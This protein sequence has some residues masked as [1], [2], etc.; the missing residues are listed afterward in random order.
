MPNLLNTRISSFLGARC[1][2]RLGGHGTAG[3][4]YIYHAV[5]PGASVRYYPHY[6]VRISSVSPRNDATGVF[7]NRNPSHFLMYFTFQL[8][9]QYV[10][11][12]CDGYQ[13]AVKSNPP[14]SRHVGAGAGQYDGTG[15]MAYGMELAMGEF[16]LVPTASIKSRGYAIP[17][18]SWSLRSNAMQPYRQHGYG[19]AIQQHL[20]I[21]GQTSIGPSPTFAH[22]VD[23]ALVKNNIPSDSWS[24][25]MTLAAFPEAEE[26]EAEEA[27]TQMTRQGADKIVMQRQFSFGALGGGARQMVFV[28]I[29]TQTSSAGS[30]PDAF[31]DEFISQRIME[32][33]GNIGEMSIWAVTRAPFEGFP[34]F[35][36]FLVGYEHGTW[37]TLG[38]MQREWSDSA[39][40]IGFPF[41]ACA[42]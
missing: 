10:H 38:T 18:D 33:I 2:T 41:G 27:L 16:G 29:E 13:W 25:H 21:I 4:I 17:S 15:V 7:D 14:G 12:S 40:T 35:D 42:A 3:P 26:Q 24:S 19:T 20:Y 32:P 30:Y 31:P 37:K 34:E 28:N 22:T 11:Q 1:Q 36:Y 9:A 23:Y 5:H 39:N 8:S 6:Y